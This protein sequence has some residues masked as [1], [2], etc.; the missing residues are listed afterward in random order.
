MRIW[1]DPIA[2]VLL[3]AGL[4]MLLLSGSY[5]TEQGKKTLWYRQWVPFYKNNPYYSERGQKL[6][7]L[8]SHSIALGAIVLIASWFV[9]E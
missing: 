1:L 9:G 7:R 3:A 5:R 6:V 4:I 2:I 8:A